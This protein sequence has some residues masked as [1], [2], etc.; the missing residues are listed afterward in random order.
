MEGSQK[1]YIAKGLIGGGTVLAKTEVEKE[2]VL[3]AR[4]D[5]SIFCMTPIILPE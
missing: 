2:K 1:I 4:S 3:T 5:A